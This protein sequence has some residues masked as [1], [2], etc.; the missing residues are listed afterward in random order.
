VV[1]NYA[2][3]KSGADEVVARIGSAGGVAKAVQADVRKQEDVARLLRETKAQFCK[4]DIL[5]NNAGVFEFAS[6][7]KITTESF[8]R[9]FD[10][11]VLGL[12]LVTQEA[13]KLMDSSGGS[14][15]NISSIAGRKPSLNNTV[16]AATKAAVDSITIAL[17]QELG[18]RKIRVNALDPGMVET[19]GFLATGAMD[20][21]WLK[22]AV[23]ATP[24]GRIAQPEDVARAAVFFASE[25]SGWITGEA[26]LLAGG[27][28]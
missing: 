5:V 18:P 19:E 8:H 11:N 14:I 22:D 7:D 10:T 16:Y 4:L 9:M 23:K 17:A 2:G 3:S 24:L 27:R 12:L 26:I 1:V 13:V 6:L 28:R 15:I 20:S 25:E 21:V